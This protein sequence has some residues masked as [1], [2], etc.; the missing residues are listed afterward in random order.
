MG[1]GDLFG[2]VNCFIWGQ[3]EPGKNK[4]IETIQLRL[5]NLGRVFLCILCARRERGEHEPHF[6]LFLAKSYP[7]GY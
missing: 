6:G 4:K 5:S 1:A 2:K 7:V 3:E